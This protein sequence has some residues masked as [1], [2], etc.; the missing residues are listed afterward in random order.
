M[1]ALAAVEGAAQFAGAVVV[2]A[3]VSITR[4]KAS[5]PP[6]GKWT[7]VVVHQRHA[8]IDAA[9]LEV[10]IQVPLSIGARAGFDAQPGNEWSKSP[11]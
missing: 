5:P 9:G 1:L 6:I 7:V 3:A 11:L 2:P 10:V 4:R 8:G